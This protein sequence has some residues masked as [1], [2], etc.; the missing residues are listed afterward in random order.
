MWLRSEVSEK[1]CKKITGRV[2]VQPGGITSKQL[3]LNVRNDIRNIK[4]SD[5]EDGVTCEQHKGQHIKSKKRVA[6]SN[7]K[8]ESRSEPSKRYR[9]PGRRNY[10]SSRGL[11][12]VRK[13]YENPDAGSCS[14]TQ[15]ILERISCGRTRGISSINCKQNIV[16]SRKLNGIDVNNQR[17]RLLCRATKWH[18][19]NPKFLKEP[20]IENGNVFHKKRTC[21]ERL[22][23]RRR[24][25]NGINEEI[26]QPKQEKVVQKKVNRRLV[27]NIQRRTFCDDSSKAGKTVPQRKMSKG[28]KKCNMNSCDKNSVVKKMKSVN[29]KEELDVLDVSGSSYINNNSSNIVVLSQ[30]INPALKLSSSINSKSN[31]G[32]TQTIKNSNVEPVLDVKDESSSKTALCE[33]SGTDTLPRE[34]NDIVN[35][36]KTEE[37]DWFPIGDPKNDSEKDGGKFFKKKVWKKC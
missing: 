32:T 22:P 18:K 36:E 4:G 8:S 29:C 27:K 15:S 26:Y 10:N 33:D 5:R 7:V 30:Y 12:S 3:Q 9:S 11:Q 31:N 34:C 13:T 1:R 21:Y 17:G 20:Y 6:E 16:R 19:R 2:L 23:N 14:K 28:G 35:N 25:C 37:F 24:K